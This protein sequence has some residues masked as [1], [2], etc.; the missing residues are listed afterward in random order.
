MVRVDDFR[1]TDHAEL[2]WIAQVGTWNRRGWITKR[3][4]SIALG[5][6]GKSHQVL[7]HFQSRAMR[8]TAIVEQAS[9]R[10]IGIGV[11]ITLREHITLTVQESEGLVTGFMIE[12]H[13]FPEIRS[14]IQVNDGFPAALH[15]LAGEGAQETRA[16]RLDDERPQQTERILVSRGMA[17]KR[18]SAF[19]GIRLDI[20]FK[21]TGL[22]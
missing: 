16:T 7:L 22:P 3:I 2:G 9:C 20:P 19:L 6:V 5:L 1:T 15:V 21:F 13:E 14:L 10:P 17:M 12:N 11:G 4:R 8:F 18:M